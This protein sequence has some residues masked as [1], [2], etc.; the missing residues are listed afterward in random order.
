[1]SQ[2]CRSKPF[3]ADARQFTGGS[4]NAAG[5]IRWVRSEKGSAQWI[6]PSAQMG[7][8]L[9]LRTQFGVARVSPNDWVVKGLRG[10]FYPI[11]PAIFSEMFAER[12]ITQG[13][14]VVANV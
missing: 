1:M 7:E 14:S 10:E 11:K 2:T 13:D 8:T 4:E 5:I 3:F 12:F 9:G 6:G